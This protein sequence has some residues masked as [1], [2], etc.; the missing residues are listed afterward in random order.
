MK[1]RMAV[2]APGGLE[3]WSSFFPF[4]K[5]LLDTFG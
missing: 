1:I 5:A 3:F 4:S 2:E